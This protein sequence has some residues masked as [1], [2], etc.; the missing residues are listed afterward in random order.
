MTRDFNKIVP[1]DREICYCMANVH[2]LVSNCLNCGKIVCDYE[3]E[4]PCLFCGNWVDNQQT[5]FDEARNTESFKT[6]IEHRDRLID[7]DIN[8]QA[9]LGIKDQRVDWYEIENDTWQRDENRQFAKEARIMEQHNKEEMED[10]MF[11]SIGLDQKGKADL[12]MK[13]G[14]VKSGDQINRAALEFLTEI[15]DEDTF[16]MAEDRIRKAK[17]LE[18]KTVRIEACHNLDE[19]SLAL[20]E[21]MKRESEQNPGYGWGSMPEEEKIEPAQAKKEGVYNPIEDGLSKRLQSENPFDEF[22]T[23]FE[24]IAKEK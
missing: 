13:R 4:G 22:K 23:A 5:E 12:S 21:T 24:K 6:A 18:R 11:I 20:F 3:G 19:K 17:I 7:Y 8:S 2:N 15:Q 14:V 16:A 10:S 9:R 1:K